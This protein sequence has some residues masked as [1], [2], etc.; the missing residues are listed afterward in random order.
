M[1]LKIYGMDSWSSNRGATVFAPQLE[2]LDR[3]NLCS[4]NGEIKYPKATIFDVIS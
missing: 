1:L 4:V 3:Y 2:V